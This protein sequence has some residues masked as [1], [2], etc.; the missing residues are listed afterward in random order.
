[1]NRIPQRVAIVT[2]ASKGIGAG[3]AAAFAGAGYAVVA[4][5]RSIES[6]DDPDIVAVQGD[7]GHAETA[8]GATFVTDETLHL[9]GGQAAGH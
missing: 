8:Q 1:M 4:T 6:F 3:V 7:V 2:G 5:S 9:D